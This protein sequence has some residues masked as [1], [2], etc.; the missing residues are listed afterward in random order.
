MGTARLLAQWPFAV[1]WPPSPRTVR[2]TPLLS[3]PAALAGG[4]MRGGTSWRSL[5]VL[6]AGLGAAIAPCR[7]GQNPPLHQ[8]NGIPGGSV[9]L[10]A[11]RSSAKDVL[12]IEWDFNGTLVIAEYKAGALKRPN[13]KDR[14]G[15]RLEM[16]DGSELEI[17]NLQVEDSGRYRCH[18]TLKSGEIQEAAF[19]LLV[20]ELVPPPEISGHLISKM[21]DGCNVTLQC[22]VPGKGEL[23]VSWKRGDLPGDLERGLSWYQI[24]NHGRDLHLW[25][26]PNS[27]DSTFTCLVSNPVDGKNAS[28]NLL[29]ICP[30]GANILSGGAG[31]KRWRWPIAMGFTVL[32]SAALLIWWQWMR[33]EVPVIADSE[34][35]GVRTGEGRH[36]QGGNEE[37]QTVK[38]TCLTN[39]NEEESDATSP[40]A[41]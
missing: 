10:S 7:A 41:S 30:S 32:L 6:L 40:N 2:Q 22:Q 17:K 39:C 26:Q 27:S 35:Q 38:P 15:P 20:H 11:D 28:V 29:T 34:L 13:P 31:Q 5:L 14:F 25:W 36:P 19:H 1:G 33:R 16:A 21:P 9:Q 8:V 3:S 12:H 18:V 24:S 4:A 37:D 23:N